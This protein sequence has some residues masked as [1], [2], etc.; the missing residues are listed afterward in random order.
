MILLFYLLVL[1]S[2]DII[3]QSGWLWQD[4]AWAL[5]RWTDAERVCPGY[6][7]SCG[8]PLD[9]KMRRG[10]THRL[11]PQVRL[12][13]SWSVAR[14]H[15][16]ALRFTVSFWFH[17]HSVCQEYFLDGGMKRMLEKDEKS[18]KLA[19]GLAASS[20]SAQPYS[21]IPRWVQVWRTADPRIICII[22]LFTHFCSIILNSCCLGKVFWFISLAY[23]YSVIRHRWL[24]LNGC[25]MNNKWIICLLKL[26]QHGGL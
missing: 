16:V 11:V 20:V 9:E 4:L 2:S 7:E 21:T 12:Q 18:A 19:M 8:Q 6:E 10:G 5:W 22:L 24:F 15:H 26:K 25:V 1:L 3:F 14:L 17:F 23:Y 13:M